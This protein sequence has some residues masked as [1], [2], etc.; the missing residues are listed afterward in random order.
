MKAF[1]KKGDEKG[2]FE[3]QHYWVNFGKLF[4]VY[5]GVF[6]DLRFQPAVWAWKWSADVEKVAV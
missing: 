4:R 6:P 1:S 3:N 2:G 5:R